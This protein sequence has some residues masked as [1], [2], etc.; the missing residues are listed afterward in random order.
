MKPQPM[1]EAQARSHELIDLKSEVEA[2]RLYLFSN[3]LA[4]AGACTSLYLIYTFVYSI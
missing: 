1:L 4:G 3:T 2:H